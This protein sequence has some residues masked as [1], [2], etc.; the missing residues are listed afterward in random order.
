MIFSCQTRNFYEIGIF[1]KNREFQGIIP[2]YTLAKVNLNPKSL[3][4]E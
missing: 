3:S 1:P 2:N 4:L